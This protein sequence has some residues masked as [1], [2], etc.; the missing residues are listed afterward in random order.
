M[1]IVGVGSPAIFHPNRAGF[2]F[3]VPSIYLFAEQRI[4]GFGFSTECSN[5]LL[6]FRLLYFSQVLVLPAMESRKQ[7]TLFLLIRK[8]A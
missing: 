2:D 4:A 7:H 8:N 6:V 5:H 3:E 1:A